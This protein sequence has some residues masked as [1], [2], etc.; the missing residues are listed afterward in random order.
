[1]SMIDGEKP[2]AIILNIIMP[3]ISGLEVLRHMQGEPGLTRLPV[4][5]VS[6]KSLPADIKTGLE[7]AASTYMTKPVEYLDLKRAVDKVLGA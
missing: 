1:M 4:I 7:A 6:A 2:A 5:V 3:D